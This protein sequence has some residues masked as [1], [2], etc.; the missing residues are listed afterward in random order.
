MP[1][2]LNSVENPTCYRQKVVN[3]LYKHL[4]RY[5]YTQYYYT[6]YK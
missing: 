2:E 4:N 5:K 1:G 6:K 3:V